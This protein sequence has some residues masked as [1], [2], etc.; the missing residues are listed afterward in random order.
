MGVIKDYILEL[1]PPTSNVI[2]IVGKM[3]EGDPWGN[4]YK[5]MLDGKLDVLLV[6]N[7]PDGLINTSD[8]IVWNIFV[9]N[10]EFQALLKKACDES[11]LLT[12]VMSDYIK[13]PL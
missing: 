13:R 12:V 8:D 3:R 4:S 7:G 10:T 6:S 2:K 5:A 1:P 11:K 9:P